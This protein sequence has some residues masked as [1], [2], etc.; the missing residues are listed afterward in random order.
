MTSFREAGFL[1]AMLTCVISASAAPCPN[2]VVAQTKITTAPEQPK[3]G[4]K[5]AVTIGVKYSFTVCLDNNTVDNATVTPLDET[6]QTRIEF[7]VPGA[8]PQADLTGEHVLSLVAVNGTV[9][10][11]KV[12]RPACK[13]CH[14]RFAASSRRLAA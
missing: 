14:G 10:R 8:P 13:P 5:V 7:T 4:Q 6:G 3:I 1:G 2:G 11:T 9:Y 12:G